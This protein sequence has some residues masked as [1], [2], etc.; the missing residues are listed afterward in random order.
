[1]PSQPKINGYSA[2]LCTYIELCRS[3]GKCTFR[4][5]CYR[6]ISLSICGKEKSLC[7][8]DVRKR[9]YGVNSLHQENFYSHKEKTSSIHIKKNI[10]YNIIRNHFPYISI[11]PNTYILKKLF[12]D[13]VYTYMKNA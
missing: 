11:I 5:V 13:C 4:E 12:D 1:M 2:P 7:F 10:I 6:A 3:S 8:Y 9:Y